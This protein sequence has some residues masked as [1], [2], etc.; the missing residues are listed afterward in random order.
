[1][2]NIVLLCVRVNV[3]LPSGPHL[4]PKCSIL[5]PLCHLLAGH[6]HLPTQLVDMFLAPILTARHCIAVNITHIFAFAETFYRLLPGLAPFFVV[7]QLVYQV[8]CKLVLQRLVIQGLLFQVAL[9]VLSHSKDA[10]KQ[11]VRITPCLDNMCIAY[12]ASRDVASRY[13]KCSRV[14]CNP[15]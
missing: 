10:H 6:E 9:L 7:V 1:M 5:L 12:S 2:A 4:L 15:G 14:F 11:G 3:A 13:D 8:P